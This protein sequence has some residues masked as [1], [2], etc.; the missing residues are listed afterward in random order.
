MSATVL[1]VHVPRRIHRRAQCGT[2]QR[3]S[4][5]AGTACTR[6][7]LQPAGNIWPVNG[8]VFDEFMATEAVVAGRRPRAAGGWAGDHHDGVPIFVLSRREPGSEIGAVLAGHYVNDVRTAMS[9]AK[10]AAGDKNVLVHGAGTAQL[11]RGRRPRRARDPSHPGP[12]RPRAPSLRQPRSR[13]HRAG[14]HPDPRGRGRRHPHALPCPALTSVPVAR[15]DRARRLRCRRRS[16]KTAV[17]MSRRSGGPCLPTGSR[18][19]GHGGSRTDWSLRPPAAGRR[20][21]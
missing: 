3:G 9:E 10:R 20:G 21:Q 13:A 16:R 4:A 12:P 1:Y 6:G 5:T 18:T 7:A 17:R 11:A 14:A 15:H 8:Q 2:G 19:P